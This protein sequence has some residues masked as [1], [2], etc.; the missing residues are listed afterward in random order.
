MAEYK[1]DA[2]SIRN[3]IRWGLMLAAVGTAGFRLPRLVD[4][5]RAWRSA[6]A[7]EDSSVA[8]GW[9][10]VLTVESIGVLV[11]LAIGLGAFYVLRPRAKGAK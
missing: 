8:E 2:D 6:L 7:L 4:E 5:F 9:H 10:R 3:A 11:V 1:A